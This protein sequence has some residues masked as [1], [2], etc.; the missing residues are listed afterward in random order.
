[1]R[2]FAMKL[3]QLCSYL[4]CVAISSFMGYVTTFYRQIMT[5]LNLKFLAL[6]L[7]VGIKSFP[8]AVHSL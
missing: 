4:G 6:G 1:M 5:D 7:K 3:S 8:E 2:I